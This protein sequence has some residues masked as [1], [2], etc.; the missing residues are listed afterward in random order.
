MIFNSDIMNLNINNA[1]PFL[2]FK[3]LDQIPFVTHAFSTRMGGVSTDEF[4]SMN[5][6]FARGDKDENVI[7]NYKRLCAAVGVS[8]ESLTASAQDHHTFVRRVTA[9]NCGVGITRPKD[10]QSVDALVTNEPGVTLVT[11]F[12]DCTPL[13]FVDAKN[14]AIAAAHAGWRGTVGE[15][16][17]LTIEKMIGEFSTDPG[18]L[19]VTVGPAIGKCCYE[20]DEPVADEFRKLHLDSEK[21][22][23]EK[24]GGKYMIDLLEANT[25]IIM[26]TGVPRENITKSDICTRCSSDMVWSHRATGGK[27]GGMCALLAVK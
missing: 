19:I 24:D 7:E 12:A 5:M 2:T 25:Q 17:R 11:Y 23:Y 18:D 14:K 4:T 13:L 10:I 27:R 21:F 22:I 20:V 9:E 15:I 3:V 8:F 1:V 6:S 16:G 26:K